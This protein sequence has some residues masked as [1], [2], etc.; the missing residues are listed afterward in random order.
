ME[1]HSLPKEE[2]TILRELAK[3]QAELA[4]LP[5]MEERKKLWR[6]MNDGVEGSRPPFAIESWT[7]DRDFLPEDLGRCETPLG[8]RLER[9]FLRHIRHHEILGDDHVCPDTLDMG[10]HV[11]NNEFGIE[12]ETERVKDAEGVETGYHF[13]HPIQDLA[14]DGF[15]MIK[16]SEFGV[17]REATLDYKAFLEST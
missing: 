16:P 6:D 12:I 11:W 9:D 13:K 10:W 14:V 17:N 15:D 7:F 1:E 3:R 2:L 4:A 8:R 5:V